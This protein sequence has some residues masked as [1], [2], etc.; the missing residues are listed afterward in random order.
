MSYGQGESA[1]VRIHD[2]A[3]V[4]GVSTATVSHALNG[5][6]KVS[7]TTRRLVER[8]AFDL[9]YEPN[10]VATALRRRRSDVLGFVSDEIATVRRYMHAEA[11][12]FILIPI[13]AALMARYSG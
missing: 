10:R 11:T 8:V 9:G 5:R 7:S 12:V 3:R 6:G 4:A 13:F 1:R 2:V